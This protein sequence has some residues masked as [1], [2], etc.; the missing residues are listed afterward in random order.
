MIYLYFILSS[1]LNR[2][3]RSMLSYFFRGCVPGVV[4]PSCSFLISLKLLQF[5]TFLDRDGCLQLN[6]ILIPKKWIVITSIPGQF[7][8][9]ML[10]SHVQYGCVS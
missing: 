8:D 5:Q 7:T 2:K 1:W 9:E 6:G 3:Y 10:A 4:V